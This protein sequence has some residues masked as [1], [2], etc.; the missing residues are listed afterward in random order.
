MTSLDAPQPA[1][2]SLSRYYLGNA[3]LHLDREKDDGLPSMDEVRLEREIRSSCIARSRARNDPLYD[4]SLPIWPVSL[5][6]CEMDQAR[7][8]MMV[9]LVKTFL[10]VLVVVLMSTVLGYSA[11]LSCLDDFGGT[12]TRVI[13]NRGADAAY[14][15]ITEEFPV[16]FSAELSG[17]IEP[18]DSERFE[19][20]LSEQ[21]QLMRLHLRSPGGNVSE[22]MKMG[23]MIR[24]RFLPTIAVPYSEA[25]KPATS[26][27]CGVD[28]L[29]PCCVS[30]CALMY[31]GGAQWFVADRLG[32]HR[33]TLEDLGDMDYD[34]STNALTKAKNAIQIYLDEMEIDPKVNS[35]MMDTPANRLVVWTIDERHEESADPDYIYKYPPSIHDWLFAKCRRMGDRSRLDC[36]AGQLTEE[37]QRRAEQTD[38]EALGVEVKFQEM[39]VQDLQE[40][41]RGTG[42]PFLERFYAERR[43]ETLRL[44]QDRRMIDGLA[45]CEA[46]RYFDSRFTG[47]TMIKGERLTVSRALERLEAITGDAQPRSGLNPALSVCK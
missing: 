8:Q 27:I 33:P 15:P 21:K 47:N 4:R 42:I 1:S 36:M 7:A 43:L 14:F 18:G 5:G 20:F 28:T 10:V 38:G 39:S 41:L 9:K 44:E 40:V 35:L 2:S 37:R 13:G 45:L 32:L 24:K 29:P 30:A 19:K 31:F 34:A 22:A 46:K 16:C 12:E 6:C 3:I 25:G 17:S 26:A 11:A 23:R